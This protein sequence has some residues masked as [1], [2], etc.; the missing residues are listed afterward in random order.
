MGRGQVCLLSTDGVERPK[1]NLMG[2]SR[3]SLFQSILVGD[4]PE[5]I[6]G[7]NV[8]SMTGLALLAGPGE[9]GLIDA[10]V[11]A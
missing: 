6:C 7:A 1:S 3:Q 4:G 10:M 8:D 5:E 11:A 2:V 9:S